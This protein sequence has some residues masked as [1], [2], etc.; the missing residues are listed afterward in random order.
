MGEIHPTLLSVLKTQLPS[1]VS[2]N[3]IVAVDNHVSAV[4][5]DYE[6][7]T[8]VKTIEKVYL[9][10]LYPLEIPPL[11]VTPPITLSDVLVQFCERENL[12]LIPNVDYHTD[13]TPLDMEDNVTLV[14]LRVL[15]ESLFYKGTLYIPV[16]K[17]D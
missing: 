10:R 13:D 14:P 17:V 11:V 12:F 3:G 7:Q 6:N 1:V 8:V 4:R 16:K 2:V 15:P 9:D 5:L